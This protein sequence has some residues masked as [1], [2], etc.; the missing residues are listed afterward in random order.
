M[1]G[2]RWFNSSLPQT[3]QIANILLYLNAFLLLIDTLGGGRD[4]GGV[5]M[6]LLAGSI[7]AC[8]LGGLGLANEQKRGYQV[9]ILAA[10][11]PFIVRAYLAYE[12]GLGLGFI[13]GF[14]Q[15]LSLLFEVALIALLLHTQSKSYVKTWFH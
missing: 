8:V 15:L 4:L 3:L 11:S 5:L 12:F 1:S 13:L 7:V 14:N 2:R 6:L 9:A 10:F